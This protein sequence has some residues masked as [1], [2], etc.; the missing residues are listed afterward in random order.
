VRGYPRPEVVPAH[1]IHLRFSEGHAEAAQR[2][3]DLPNS[4]LPTGGQGVPPNALARHRARM[5]GAAAVVSGHR[6]DR[7]SAVFG[8]VTYGK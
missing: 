6:L 7:R 1:E 4:Y 8:P 2:K 3:A 5:A